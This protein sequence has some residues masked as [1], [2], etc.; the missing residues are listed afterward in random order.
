V[1]HH[2]NVREIDDMTEAPVVQSVDP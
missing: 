2:I 1:I